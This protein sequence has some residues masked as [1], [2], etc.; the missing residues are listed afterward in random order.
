MSNDPGLCPKC[1][2]PLLIVSC[3]CADCSEMSPK[4]LGHRAYTK[5]DGLHY[6]KDDTRMRPEEESLITCEHCRSPHVEIAQGC[7]H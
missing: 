3:L 2:K 6:E 1:G 5:P 7:N 4:Y